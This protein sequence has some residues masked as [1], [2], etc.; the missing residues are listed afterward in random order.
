[1][2]RNSRHPKL[3]T[4][5]TVSPAFRK[6]VWSSAAAI[7]A[8]VV[9]YLALVVLSLSLAVACMWGGIMVTRFLPN[10]LGIMIAAMLVGL[11]IMIIIFIVKFIF[12]ETRPD[13]SDSI[14]ISRNDQPGLVDFIHKLAGDIGTSKPRKIFLS[15]D[16]NACVFYNSGFWSMFLPVPKNLRIGLGLVNSLNV[17]ELQ[18]VIA[19]EFG[20]FSQR[21]MKLGSFVYQVNRI[22]HDMLFNN[23]GYAETIQGFVRIHSIFGLSAEITGSVV[24]CIQWTLHQMY[25]LVNK[26]YMDLSRQMEFHADLVAAS[27]SGSNNIISALRRIEFSHACFEHTLDLCN[28]IWKDNKVVADMYANHSIVLRHRGNSK[29]FAMQDGIPVPQALN[30]QRFNRVNFKDQW[31]SHPTIE[32]RSAYLSAFNLSAEVK[33]ESAWSLF[34]NEE[35]L[36]QQFTAILYRHLP[37]EEQT[38]RMSCDDF[39]AF[40]I[41][42]TNRFSMPAVFKGYF[43]NRE[44]NVFDTAPELQNT[45]STLIAEELLSDENVKLPQ[46]IQSLTQDIAILQS[47]EEKSI[48]TSTFDFDG[49]KYRRTKASE[50]RTQLEAELKECSDK[51]DKLDR[52]LFLCFDRKIAEQEPALLASYRAQ[53]DQYF[54]LRKN[55]AEYLKL[56][57]S[58]IQSLS[59]IYA[60][61]SLPAD[62]I[63]KIIGAVKDQE[64]LFKESLY[65]WSDAGAFEDD[66]ELN[67]LVKKFL[68]EEYVYF[69]GEKFLDD[70][71]TVLDRIVQESWN[72]ILIFLHD[73]FRQILELKASVL[74][75][76]RQSLAG[77]S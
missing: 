77:A 64:P 39:E 73:R 3:S 21:S 2:S 1:M 66:R 5:N 58:I 72:N 13:E 10:L 53:Y 41:H 57:E 51:L 14:E 55:A 29:Q 49:K 54:L 76:N 48:D 36:R 45:G 6:A 20:H 61:Q 69:N 46:K 42:T 56:L 26:N 34:R 8:V 32:E 33:Q 75:S 40:H 63:K 44:I 31:A 65:K 52:K 17:S 19:H 62:D 68:A 27:Y 9:V 28:R 22:I 7:I 12:A 43:D 30:S 37:V 67:D 74:T 38:A 50:V 15:T 71:L 25:K 59:P 16:V 35:G 4:V 70:E 23:K 47:I 18:A 11:G 60:G 24:R